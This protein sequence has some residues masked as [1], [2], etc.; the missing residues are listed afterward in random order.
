M[1]DGLCNWLTLVVALVLSCGCG[2]PD[3]ASNG[4]NGAADGEAGEHKSEHIHEGDDAFIWRRTDIEQCHEDL[5]VRD[6][7]SIL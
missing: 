3:L 2:P 6:G 1:K 4:G 5:R 7:L